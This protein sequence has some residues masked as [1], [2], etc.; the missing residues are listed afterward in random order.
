M[1]CSLNSMNSIMNTHLAIYEA[2]EKR[3]HCSLKQK[4]LENKEIKPAEHTQYNSK[5]LLFILIIMIEL[6]QF[7]VTNL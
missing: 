3:Y 1:D 2:E 6:F 4:N 7:Y 5:Q